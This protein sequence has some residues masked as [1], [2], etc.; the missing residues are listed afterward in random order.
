MTVTILSDNF[1]LKIPTP[2][3]GEFIGGWTGVQLDKLGQSITDGI[4]NG[5]IAIMD[6]VSDIV[7]WGSRVG[8]MFCIIAYIVA[9]DRKSVALGVKLFLAYIITAVVMSKL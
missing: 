6:T 3:N 8:I 9:K 2:E 4:Y 1:M 5:F 7:F